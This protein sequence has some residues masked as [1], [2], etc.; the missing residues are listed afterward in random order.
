MDF[1]ALSLPEAAYL[2]TGLALQALLR[3]AL[4]FVPAVLV[5]VTTLRLLG[6]GGLTAD[7]RFMGRVVGY[8]AASALILVLFWPEAVG[9]LGGLPGRVDP[10]RVASYAAQQDPG[11]T[12]RTAQDT[13]LVPAPLLGP[14]VLPTGFRLLLR[15]FTET[16]LALAQA[17]NAQT[18]RTFSAVVPMQ[19]LLTQKLTGE[20]QAAVADWVHGCYLP[21]QARVLQRGGGT[22]TFTDLLPWGGSALEAVLGGLETTP[23]A[24]TGLVST[25]LGFLGLGGTPTTPVRCDA[26]VQR[27]EQQVQAWLGSQRTARATPLSVVFQRELG[28]APADQARFLL[29]REMLQVAGPLLPAP[30]LTGTY[31]G[32]RG[33]ALL[34]SVAKGA[35][36]GTTVAGGAGAGTGAVAGGIAGAANELQRALDGAT[37]LVSVAT[38]LTWWGPYIL[39][40][41]NLVLLGLF[42]LVVLWAL[43]PQVQF[44]PLALYFAALFFTTATPLWWALVDVAARLAAPGPTP[45]PVL[46]PGD[47]LQSLTASTAVTALGI[48]IIPIVTGLV[49][50]GSLRALSGLWRGGV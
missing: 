6:Q 8:V 11:A 32:L 19:W 21:A 14:Q 23:G 5:T 34:G 26:Y 35:G 48:L 30:S 24:Q 31:L 40:V 25:I 44:Q 2:Y 16:H 22:T 43:L 27:V 45:N 41:V 4:R 15:A 36:L 39:G 29:Y 47:W 13:G 17:L 46:A 7:R 9:R 49:I 37:S 33:I 3:G 50:F 20:A 18:P 1:V 28:M 42:P 12:V 38:W 10:Q